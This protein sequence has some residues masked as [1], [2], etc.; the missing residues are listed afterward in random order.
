V[1]SLE[2]GY[3]LQCVGEVSFDRFVQNMHIDM[4]KIQK[5]KK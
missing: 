3:R 1:S 4:A 2:K 5:N